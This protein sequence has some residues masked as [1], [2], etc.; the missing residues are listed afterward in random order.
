M[1][2]S[3]KITQL[4]STA[5]RMLYELTCDRCGRTQIVDKEN[6]FPLNCPNP[7]CENHIPDE[8]A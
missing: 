2:K 3:F 1:T 8:N 7:D 5:G 4:Y 6:T